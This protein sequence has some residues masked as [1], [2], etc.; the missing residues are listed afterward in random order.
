MK[1]IVLHIG[2]EKTATTSLQAFFTLNQERLSQAGVWYPCDERLDYCHRDAHFPLAA[3]TY[4]ECPD[5]VTPKKYFE[6]KPLFQTLFRDMEARPEGT[7]LLSAEHFSSRCSRPERI[8][9]LGEMLGDRDVE[10]ILYVRPQQ[11]LLLSAYSTFLKSGGKKTLEE[12]CQRQWLKPGAIYFNYFRMASRWWEVFGRDKVT[13]RIFQKP[14]LVE[15]DIY[16]DFIATLGLDWDEQFIIP[17]RKNPPICKELADFL[18]LANQHFPAFIEDDRAGWEMGNRFRREIEPLFPHGRP[19]RHV[20]SN[21]LEHETS[22]FFAKFNAK[23]ASAAR[24]D[25]GGE[26]FAETHIDEPLEPNASENVF[27]DEF[28]SWVIQQ[29]KSGQSLKS[30][31]QTALS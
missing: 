22:T 23:L 19:L 31:L 14:H 24:P 16:R 27:C 5:F 15:G 26:L 21:E 13:L 25:L 30:R 12:L 29:W 2:T 3:A 6:Y 1:R 10:I 8:E 11:E 9:R 20:L 28:V 18:F 17:E 4:A 7:V